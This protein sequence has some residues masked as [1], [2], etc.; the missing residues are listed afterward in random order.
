MKVPDM[1]SV[2]CK[3]LHNLTSPRARIGSLDVPSPI[4]LVH[5]FPVQSGQTDH[6]LGD[7]RW[8]LEHAEATELLV[9]PGRGVDLPDLLRHRP[10]LPLE[11]LDLAVFLAELVT[12]VLPTQADTVH[13]ADAVQPVGEP[14]GDVEGQ[15]RVL[16]GRKCPVVERHGMLAKGLV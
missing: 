8:R 4:R 1:R 7:R 9:D 11:V 14:S 3:P 13:L 15:G 16:Q 12:K 5:R 10:E 2:S 6:G